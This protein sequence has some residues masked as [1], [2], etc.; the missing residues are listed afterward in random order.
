M[1]SHGLV[2]WLQASRLPSQSYIAVPLMAGQALAWHV[3][4]S[5]SW[6]VFVLVQLYGVF[7]QLYIVYANDYADRDADP[8]NQWITPFSGGSRVLVEGKIAPQTLAKAAWLMVFGAMATTVALAV[9]WGRPWAVP[10]GLFG[11]LLLWAY[12]YSPFKLSYRGGGELLQAVG[13][14]GVLP[15]LAYYAQAGNWQGF[16]WWLLVSFV[17]LNLSNA[18]TTALPDR[19][20]D[21]AANKRTVP[22]WAGEKA[23]QWA[24]IGLHLVGLGAFVVLGLRLVGPFNAGTWGALAVAAVALVALPVLSGRARPG[25]TAIVG[26]VTASI[27]VNQAWM[28]ALMVT[29]IFPF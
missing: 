24:V 25:T 13:V 18:I 2:A 27:V 20:S 16:P 22:V 29:A 14:G 17:A 12:S 7:D 10:V 9:G 15:L 11:V 19:L 8:H 21:T 4:G 5:W 3:T 6:A 28:V 23:A 1:A 26:F